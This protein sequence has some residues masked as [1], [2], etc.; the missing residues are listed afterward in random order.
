MAY[1]SANGWPYRAAALNRK[2]TS[3]NLMSIT[4]E[5]QDSTRE[6]L[7]GWHI[8]TVAEAGFSMLDVYGRHQ[9]G[10]DIEVIRQFSDQV[11]Q[12]DEAGSLHPKAPISALPSRFFREQEKTMDPAV[13][14]DFKRQLAGFLT[15]A[16]Q[17]A[18]H[19]QRVLVDFHVCPAPIPRHYVDATEE[20][21]RLF[22]NCESI[23]KVVIFT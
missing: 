11:N 2:G 17:G 22:D 21:F 10:L 15:A 12:R 3:G 18:I 20:V 5:H 23:Q 14:N 6:S 13:L 8:L 4:R 16:A 7:N 19:A 9:N 1:R